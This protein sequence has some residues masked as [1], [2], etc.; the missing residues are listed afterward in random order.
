MESNNILIGFAI[1]QVILLLV[2][3]GFIFL[4]TSIMRG[5]ILDQEEKNSTEKAVK[6]ELEQEARDLGLK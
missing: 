2:N 1:F 4:L 6:K 5:F 3:I